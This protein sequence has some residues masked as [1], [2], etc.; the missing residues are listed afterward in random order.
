MR[1]AI[2]IAFVWVA[3]VAFFFTIIGVFGLEPAVA[4]LVLYVAVA[5]A[6]ALRPQSKEQRP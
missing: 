5:C 4:A 6:L 2:A 3:A 1:T